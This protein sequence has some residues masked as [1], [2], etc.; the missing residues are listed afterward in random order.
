MATS[1]QLNPEQEEARAAFEQLLDD[2]AEADR[3]YDDLP[4]S[5]GGRIVST[6]I[7]RF[8]DKR[9][10]DVPKG[11]PR[12]LLPGW[13]CAWRY[14]HGRLQRELERG[15]DGKIVRFMAGGWAAGKTHALEHEPSPELAWDGTLD[16]PA[17][18]ARMIDLALNCKWRVDVA[19]VFRDIEMALYGSL[20]RAKAE[21]R[22]VPL[23]D[24]AANHRRVQSSILKLMDKYHANISVSFTLVHNL[25]AR[26]LIGKS[27][28][29]SYVELAPEGP[30]HYSKRYEHYYGKAA[31][32]IE[33]LNPT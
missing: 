8:L 21:G 15:G 19:Y 10:R 7:A 22:G 31:L 5:R 18:A 9:Y 2:T 32:E 4:E 17:W 20:E 26:G 11:Q 33:G 1:P 14:S 24:L 6:D 25:G 29:V 28:P 3:I 27:L 30:L 13:E 12:D 23:A 16:Q